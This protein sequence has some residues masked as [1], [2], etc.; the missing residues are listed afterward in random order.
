MSLAPG[1]R[2]GSYELKGATSAGMII[3]TAADTSLR[4]A[5]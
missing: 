4:R 1:E 3:G 5:A 2:L